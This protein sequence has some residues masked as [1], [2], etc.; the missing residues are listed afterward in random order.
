LILARRTY[1]DLIASLPSLPPRHDVERPPIS[2]VRLRERLLLLDMDDAAVVRQWMDFVH[3]DR[4]SL[5]HTDDDVARAY[6]RLQQEITNPTLW[7]LIERRLDTRTLVAALRRR[8]AGLSPP[9][10]VGQWLEK[11][12]RNYHHPEFQLEGRYPW[13]GR[14]DQLIGQGQALAAERMMFEYTY[15]QVAELQPADPFAFEAVL[16]YLARWELI[17]RWT[18][19]D[20]V[21]GQQRFETLIKETLGEYAQL[22]AV[23]PIA[24]E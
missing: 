20:A 12:R 10:G 24:A 9:K 17:E 11:I 21:A 4:Q 14:F 5:D 22:F 23:D 8:R 2:E 1:Y 15:Q 6:H 16:V 18:S 7:T 13:I 3:W 19:L